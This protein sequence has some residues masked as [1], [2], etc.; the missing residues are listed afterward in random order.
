MNRILASIEAIQQEGRLSIIHLK[1]KSVSLRSIILDNSNTAEY[2][3]VGNKISAV[4]K[5]HEVIIS[6]QLLLNNI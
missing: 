4:F 5:E 1:S 2:L 3:K 6:K